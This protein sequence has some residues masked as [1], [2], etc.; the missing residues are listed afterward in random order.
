M[1][2]QTLTNLANALASNYGDLIID[3]LVDSSGGHLHGLGLTLDDSKTITGRLRANGK[4]YVGGGG[5]GDSGRYA[6][7]WPVLYSVGAAAS[8]GSGDAFPSASAASYAN[9][10]LDWKRNGITMEFDNLARAAARGRSFVGGSDLSAYD[11][12]FR[13][14]MKAIFAAIETQLVQDGTGNGSK[15]IDGVKAFMATSGTYGNVALTNGYWQPA[16]KDL[17]SAGV[18]LTDLQEVLRTMNANNARPTEIW[19][20]MTQFHKIQALLDAK[21]QYVTQ[22][23]QDAFVQSFLVDGIPVYPIS[24]MN[25]GTSTDDEIWFI[26]TDAMEL[27]FL[28]IAPSMGDEGNQSSASDYDGY[29][30]G[31][32]PTDPGKDSSGLFIKC[33]AQLICLNPS[34]CGAII[35][36]AV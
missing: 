3:S 2:T 26:N 20:S 30:I 27:R 28:P 31:I 35:N 15:N 6:N 33:Y 1:A 21:I 11:R 16:I 19:C 34:Q 24:A 22:Q 25:S 8:F 12:E 7:Q 17:S 10:Y 9:A 36:A 5:S 29:P 13:A 18:A 23:N 14:K 4:V 32:E